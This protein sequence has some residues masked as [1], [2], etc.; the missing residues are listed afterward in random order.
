[1]LGDAYFDMG[2][3]QK[4]KNYYNEAASILEHN[5]VMPTFSNMCYPN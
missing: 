4:S 2:E 1:M 3:Y 5:S